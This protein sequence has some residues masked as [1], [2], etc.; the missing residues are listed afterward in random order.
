MTGHECKSPLAA[1]WD[2]LMDACRAPDGESRSE[3]F[4]QLLAAYSEPHRHYHNLDHICDILSSL[5]V[6]ASEDPFLS[7]RNLRLATWYHDIVYDTKSSENESRSAAVAE[8]SLAELGLEST[9]IARVSAL[10]LMTKNH[11]APP[12]DSEA[13]LFLDADLHILEATPSV[14]SKYMRDIRAEYGWVADREFYVGRRRIL[15]RFLDRPRIYHSPYFAAGEAAAR[16]NVAA[17]IAEID[18]KLRSVKS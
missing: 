1:E 6:A 16:A 5:G 11:Q 7:T 15:Q 2:R 18:E 3:A 12:G 10:I 8:F 14:Y 13:Q 4:A 9:D 17:E